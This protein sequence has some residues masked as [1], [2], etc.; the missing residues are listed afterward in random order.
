MRAIHIQ[1]TLAYIFLSLGAW[2]LLFPGTVESLGLQPNY[3]V[4]N[5]TSRLLLQCFAP[6]AMLVGTVILSSRFLP[7]TFLIF[8]VVASV[9][10]FGF[11]YYFY[12]VR[13]MFTDWMLLDFVGNLLI[14][15]CGFLGYRL[16]T[17]EAERAPE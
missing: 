1:K 9:P 10:F 17:Q 3:F 15:G 8:G 16:S 13:S 12:F 7:R 5:D 2:P 4:G 11:N 6:Q 14:L